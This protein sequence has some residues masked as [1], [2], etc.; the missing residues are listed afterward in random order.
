MT[1]MRRQPEPEYMDDAREAEVYALA[2]FGE[3]NEAFAARLA[4]H[5]AACG[6]GTQAPARA[7]DLGTGPGDIPVRVVRRMP[8]WQVTAV[9]ASAAMIA[10][11]RT[12]A[13]EA[14][15]GD[16]IRP[17]L[18]DAKGTGLPAGAF[19]V[20]FSNSILHHINEPGALW[21]E[22]RRLARPGAL[23][24][25]RDLARPDSR[26]AARAIVARYAGGEP[27]LLQ[28]EYYRSLLASYTVEEVRVQLD[29]AGLGAVR[30]A[31][32]TDRHLDIWGPAP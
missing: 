22:V 9:D 13:G 20:V 24:F 1:G 31:M 25:F 18:A 14:G 21:A 26:A 30:V 2:D 17:V 3:V 12:A 6:G 5:W 32:A 19:D 29:G 23:V 16:R 27:E 15:L 10:F 11:A 7:V 4:E 8:A 28:D